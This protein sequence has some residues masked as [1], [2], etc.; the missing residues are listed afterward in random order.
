MDHT[1]AIERQAAERYVLGELSASEAE[2]FER[3]FFECTDC[4]DAVEAG[5]SFVEGARIALRQPL[6]A[7]P[8]RRADRRRMP[9]R[10]RWWP[11]GAFACAAAVF[12]AIVVYQS[13]F[14]IPALRQAISSA[15]VLP[16]FQLAGVSRGTVTPLQVS[17]ETPFVSVAADIPPD[18]TYPKYVCTLTSGS[19]TIFRVTANAPAAGQA[20]TVLLPVKDLS[21]GKYELTVNGEN[22]LQSAKIASYPFQLEFH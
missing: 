3:H 21:S 7:N 19:R 6:P 8:E 14:V 1:Q 10:F 4:A 5:D 15:Q 11:Q 9:L 20:I 12:A 16:A 13:A 2:D 22:G 18:A 17:R